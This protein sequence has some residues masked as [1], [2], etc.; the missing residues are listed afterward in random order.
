MKD[1]ASTKP[2]YEQIFNEMKRKI[3][4]HTFR[5]GD[6]VPSEKDLAD[7]YGVSELRAKK[8]SICWQP[9]V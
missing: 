7:E 3:S 2:M 6:R 1:A 5:I 8:H 9:K 4:T